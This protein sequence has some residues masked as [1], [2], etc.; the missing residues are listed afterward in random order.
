MLGIAFKHLPVYFTGIIKARWNPELGKYGDYVFENVHPDF[1]DIDETCPTNNADDMGFVS[2]I[3]PI[4]VQ[5]VIMRFPNAKEKMFNKLK[6]EG[7][8]VGEGEEFR[9]EDLATPI[10]IRE[11]WFKWYKRADTGEIRTSPSEIPHARS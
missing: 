1:V 5:E 4:S 6:G 11:V 8:I 7:L 9:D 10:K 3:L 2:Q